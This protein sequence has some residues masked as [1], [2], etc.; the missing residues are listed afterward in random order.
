M[1]LT[2]SIL[3]GIVVLICF[4][5]GMNIM[6]KGAMNYLPKET[7]PQ[8][9][10]DDLVRFLSGIY[11]GSGF[12]LAYAA[13]HIETLGNII[14]FFGLIVVFSG[15]GRL[16]SRYKLGSAGKYFD[17]IMMIEIVLGIA[18]MVLQWLR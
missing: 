12:M 3:L 1:A 4:F 9:I 17:S 18:I 6:R 16:Y 5:G 7:P 10:L 13:F 11:L 14:Y 15:L 2:L 8:L